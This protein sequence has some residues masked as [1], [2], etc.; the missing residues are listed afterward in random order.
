MTA[1]EWSLSLSRHTQLHKHH[2]HS[3]LFSPLRFLLLLFQHSSLKTETTS[4]W[5]RDQ[6]KKKKIKWVEATSQS[7]RHHF[8][9]LQVMHAI[10][11]LIQSTYM[12]CN[13]PQKQHFKVHA[14]HYTTKSIENKMLS[15][16]FRK[17]TVQ[18]RICEVIVSKTNFNL[19]KNYG[20]RVGW[21][22]LFIQQYLRQD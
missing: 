21:R 18:T 20:V 22:Q 8:P 14:T 10:T 1:H 16:N 7:Q 5:Q 12:K 19:A 2:Q 3:S 17:N 11:S 6:R 9:Y 4:C 13:P 15:T